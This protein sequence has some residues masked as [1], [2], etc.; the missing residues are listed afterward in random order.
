MTLDCPTIAWLIL[1]SLLLFDSLRVRGRVRRLAVLPPSDAPVLAEH[2]FVVAPGVPLDEGTRRAASAWAA[3]QGL[4]VLD[5]W[6]ADLGAT[7]ATALASVLDVERFR[8]QRL[9]SMKTAGH[10]LLVSRD[11]LRRAAIGVPADPVAFAQA[12]VR[13]K[14][15]ACMSTDVAVAPS[16]QAVRDDPGW[17]VPVLVALLGTSAPM[18]ILGQL[19]GAVLPVLGFLWTPL[20]GA[21]AALAYHLHPLVATAGTALRP[22]DLALAVPLRTLIDA[23]LWIRAVL[24]RRHRP[25]GPDPVEAARPV[26]EALLAGGVERFFEPR[27][28]TC[29]ICGGGD[30]HVRI[31]MPDMVQGKPGR[32]TLER[33]RGCGH[34]FQNPRLTIEGLDLY[35]RDFYDGL[36]AEAMETIFGFGDAPY[37]ARARMLEA[38]RNG[39]GPRRWLDVGGGHGHFCCCARDV[40][41]KARFEAL[42]LGEAIVEAERRRW[43]D[44][45]WQGLFPDVAPSLAGG[46]DVVSMSHYL[47][48]VRDP[49]AELEAAHK[50]LE[51][52]GHLLIEVPNPESWTGRVLRRFWMPWFQPQHQ[53][54]L[55]PRLLGQLL[56]EAG[57]EPVKWH[58]RE[59]HSTTDLLLAG[60]LVLRILGPTLDQPWRPRRGAFARLRYAVVWSLAPLVLAPAALLDLL[61]R[62]LLAGPGLANTY[63]VLARK[64]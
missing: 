53:H 28:G 31:R 30:L 13:L 39:D 48:H 43:V 46:F 15:F 8:S 37:L 20:G 18:L 49:R 5:L 35:Y 33:C 10:A 4:D 42:D 23:G 17:H 52:G 34:V 57:F 7:K 59:A 55:P 58:H 44:K 51:T 3:A 12:A 40:W 14:R 24:G 64:R 63:R 60:A 38:A 2:A 36:G 21:A 6:P 25:A 16:L 54:L 50:A 47:E 26:Y 45:A 1:A 32:F 41:P 62:P 61:L 9:A 11:V 56:D 22:R 29:P 19:I 27:R